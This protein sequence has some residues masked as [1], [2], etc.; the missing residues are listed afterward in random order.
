MSVL[1]ADDR[2]AVADEALELRNAGRPL[3]ELVAQPGGL[4]KLPVREALVSGQR[5][6][7]VR[8]LPAETDGPDR[9]ATARLPFGIAEKA[10]L[11]ETLG[12]V[13]GGTDVGVGLL[14][15]VVR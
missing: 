14:L 12:P 11:K 13:L 4:A 15:E 6:G 5:G 8:R 3:A 7:E 9:Q 2:V 10:V 1:V